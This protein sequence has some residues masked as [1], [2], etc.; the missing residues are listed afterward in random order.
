MPSNRSHDDA[1]SVLC[2]INMQSEKGRCTGKL[3]TCKIVLHI[4]LLLVNREIAVH[5]AVA[6]DIY[7]GFFLCCPFS[8]EVSW[9]RS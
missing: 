6:C 2:S 8:H 7:D 9:M 3:T 1:F 4:L 5:L